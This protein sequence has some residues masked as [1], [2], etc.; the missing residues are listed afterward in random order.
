M[1][2][3]IHSILTL[4]VISWRTMLLVEETGGPTENHQPVASLWQTWSHNVIHLTWSRLELTISVVIGTDC[5]VSCKSNYNTITVTTA[6]TWLLR[7][8]TNLVCYTTLNVSLYSESRRGIYFSP[9]KRLKHGR[10]NIT[11]HWIKCIFTK[12]NAVFIL[13][14]AAW[15]KK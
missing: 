3:Y 12:L 8:I 13:K 4:S 1:F 14:T 15:A 10:Q 6:L 11:L 9:Q 2:Q 5:I 7:Y